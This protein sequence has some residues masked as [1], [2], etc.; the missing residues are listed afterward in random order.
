VR[1]VLVH[2]PFG[3]PL[4]GYGAMLCLAV[5]LGRLL[6]L[7][8]AERDGLD[9]AQLSRAVLW[10][11]AF[12]FV[13][14]R[15][16]YVV[17]NLDHFHQPLDAF[18]WWQGGMVAYGGFL[19][20]FLGA[21][22]FCRLHGIRLLAWADCAAPALCVGL[23]VTRIG[24]FLGGCDFGRPWDGAWAVRFPA[25]SPAFQ[26]QTLLALL[27]AGATESLPVHPTQ[28]Y[29]S[30]AGLV[31]LGLVLLVRA[32]RK[33]AGQVFAAFVIGYSVLRYA[34]ETVRADSDRGS[35]GPFSTSQFIA[36]VTLGAAVALAIALQRR[37]P[38]PVPRPASA[39]S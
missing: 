5:V 30:L 28:L 25:G 37:S 21:I 16:L 15:L 35:V 26:Q 24:C 20:G 17:T 10:S 2:L 27:P 34:I 1:P 7:H 8:L 23:A 22:V 4:Y 36:V 19:G 3:L 29:E 13:G 6:A 32:R 31:L 39:R 33:A 14:G 38:A 12:A 18:K 9:R 11:L